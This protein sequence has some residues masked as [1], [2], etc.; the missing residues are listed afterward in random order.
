MLSGDFLV[1]DFWDETGWIGASVLQFPGELRPL[2]YG[3]SALDCTH[4]LFCSFPSSQVTQSP[5]PLAAVSQ[6]FISWQERK[7]LI[8]LF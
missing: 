4:F 5:A 8:T 2:E 3:A 6:R 1:P 7:L